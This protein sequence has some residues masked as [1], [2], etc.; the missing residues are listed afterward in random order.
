MYGD[1]KNIA[2]PYDV[3]SNACGRDSLKE[4][5]YL[6]FTKFVTDIKDVKGT[7]CVAECRTNWNK[8]F[9]CHT[10]SQ[11]TDC[12]QIKFYPSVAYFNRFC[13]SNLAE[14][15]DNIRGEPHSV[16]SETAESY[17]DVEDNS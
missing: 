11:I 1:L 10:N 14:D 15:T 5:P 12:S 17:Y 6:F 2:Q 16:L 7:V 9:K 4:Y 13:V 3:D 8:P